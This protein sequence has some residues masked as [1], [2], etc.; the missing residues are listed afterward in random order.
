[1]LVGALVVLSCSNAREEAG[2]RVVP[3]GLRVV[4]LEGGT[5]VLEVVALTLRRETANAELYAA[6]RNKGE[7]AACSAAL[8]VELFDEAGQSLAAGITGLLTR[9][10][11]RLTDGSDAIAACLSP[12]SV[13]MAA[14]LDLPADLAIEQVE[15]VVYRTPYFALDVVPIEGVAVHVHRRPGDAETAFTGTLENR[16][17]VAVARPSVSVFPLDSVG[18]PLGIAVGRGADDIPPGG[19]WSFE[20]SALTLYER[21]VDYIAYPAGAIGD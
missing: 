4:P 10:F 8:S 15:S 14:V 20:T 19:T 18:R 11:F 3:E 2:A 6:V 5:G 12:G 13:S 17:G 21:V 7:R 1:M 16:L 9:E